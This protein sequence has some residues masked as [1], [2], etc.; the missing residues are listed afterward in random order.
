[1]TAGI[2]AAASVVAGLCQFWGAQP[3]PGELSLKKKF[4]CGL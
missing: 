1:M 4:E 2:A 3:E